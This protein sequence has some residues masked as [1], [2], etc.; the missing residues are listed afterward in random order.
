MKIKICFLASGPSQGR[1]ELELPEG[2]TVGHAVE[3]LFNLGQAPW[4]SHVFDRSTG[5]FHGT[6]TVNYRHAAR[7]HILHEGDEVGILPSMAGGSGVDTEAG[8]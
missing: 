2:A 1:M 6:L 4:M 8:R 7:D 5:N 3:A